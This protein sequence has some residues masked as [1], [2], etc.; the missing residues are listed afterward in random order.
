MDYKVTITVSKF[1]VW[2]C[3]AFV[4]LTTIAGVVSGGVAGLIGGLIG[5]VVL[6]LPLILIAE[7]SHALVEIAKNTRS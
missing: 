2:I 7:A 5:G 4:V 1:I 3:A 6:S